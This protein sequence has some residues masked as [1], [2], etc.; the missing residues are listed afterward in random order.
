M[1]DEAKAPPHRITIDLPDRAYQR[2][3]WCK[4]ETEAPS[5][6]SVIRFALRDYQEKLMAARASKGPI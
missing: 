2:L 5:M 3:L 4:A 6:V 1:S